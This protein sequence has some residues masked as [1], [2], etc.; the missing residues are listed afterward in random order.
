MKYTLIKSEDVQRK[1]KVGMILS[2][3]PNI[4][5]CGIV[6]ENMKEGHNGE[7]YNTK[8]TFTYIVLEG[9]GSFFLDDEEVK[10]SNGDMLSIPPNTRIYFKGELKMILITTPA[11]R[12]ED[13]VITKDKIW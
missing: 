7:F 6:L 2:V 13:E 12:P 1:E 11:W 4:N 10:V 8:S 3:Y 9:N 5:D